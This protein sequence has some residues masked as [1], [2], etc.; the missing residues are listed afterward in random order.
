M[1]RH[2]ISEYNPGLTSILNITMLAVRPPSACRDGERD[3]RVVY[4]RKMYTETPALAQ[5]CW[6]SRLEA[7]SIVWGENIVVFLDSDRH[8]KPVY[9]YGGSFID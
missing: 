8:P 4:E 7:L 1:D 9:H 2:K 6:D 5:A 3:I